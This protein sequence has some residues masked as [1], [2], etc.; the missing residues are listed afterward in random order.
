MSKDSQLWHCEVC[1]DTTIHDVGDPEIGDNEFWKSRHLPN[2]KTFNR[3]AYLRA[4]VCGRDHSKQP[5]SDASV[6]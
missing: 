5:D 4:H 6:R 1:D 2:Y 3:G